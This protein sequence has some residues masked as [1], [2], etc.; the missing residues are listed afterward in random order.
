M[1]PGTPAAQTL[2]RLGVLETPSAQA[3]AR[4][5]LLETQLACAAHTIVLETRFPKA[6]LE[7]LD[8]GVA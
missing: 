2:T 5:G 6:H 3:R 1:V 4:L 7:P 8:A